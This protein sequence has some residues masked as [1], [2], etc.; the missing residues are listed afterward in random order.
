MDDV[1]LQVVVVDPF[2]PLSAAALPES[3]TNTATK[4]TASAAKLTKSAGEGRQLPIDVAGNRIS[5]HLP[6]FSRRLLTALLR[7]SSKAGFQWR[8]ARL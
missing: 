2:L 5:Y 8:G 3:A 7:G 1:F 6:P 4:L